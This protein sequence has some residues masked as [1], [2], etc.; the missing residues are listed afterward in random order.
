MARQHFLLHLVNSCLILTITMCSAYTIFGDTASCRE[1]VMAGGSWR[2]IV[3]A[4]VLLIC[5]ANLVLSAYWLCRSQPRPSPEQKEHSELDLRREQLSEQRDSTG[6]IYVTCHLPDAPTLDLR[7]LDESA[8]VDS[9]GQERGDPDI[10]FW[11]QAPASPKKQD[12]AQTPHFPQDDDDDDD[13]DDLEPIPVPAM[14]NDNASL[15][16][17]NA[18]DTNF[19]F[20]NAAAVPSHFSVITPRQQRAADAL[21]GAVAEVAVHADAEVLSAPSEED[22]DEMAGLGV[23]D[24]QE[25]EPYSAAL[26]MDMDEAEMR[27]LILSKSRL[28]MASRGVGQRKA[29]APKASR[30]Q[31]ARES[32]A[33]AAAHA[34]QRP[35]VLLRRLSDETPGIV[36]FGVNSNASAEPF[37][38]SSSSA[39]RTADAMMKGKGKGRGKTKAKSPRSLLNQLRK[40]SP[41]HCHEQ[42]TE[43]NVEIHCLLVPQAGAVVPIPDD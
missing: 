36:R 4:A 31:K 37:G 12:N 8:S 27:K 42:E 26:D 16:I 5:C 20:M 11:T 41:R 40:I 34:E 23:G 14:H 43:E 32:V 19:K 6:D 28:R 22:K 24:G 18:Q 9:H 25:A 33:V 13:A 38:S 35:G 2:P 39:I 3:I 10:S 21:E 17:P 30:K 7:E 29:Y 15:P 1:C